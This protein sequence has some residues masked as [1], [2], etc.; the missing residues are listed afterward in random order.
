[1]KVVVN[2]EKSLVN[3]TLHQVHSPFYRENKN[4]LYLSQNLAEERFR[5]KYIFISSIDLS[6]E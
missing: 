4:G 5:K 2:L 3:E 1:M 6:S